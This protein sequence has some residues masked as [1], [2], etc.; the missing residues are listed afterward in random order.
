MN[1]MRIVLKTPE[2]VADFIN[3]CA[4]YECDINLYD[5]RNTL[6]AKSLMG[7]FAVTQGESN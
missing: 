1:R 6:D 4:K 7:V 2:M 5:Q 3:I